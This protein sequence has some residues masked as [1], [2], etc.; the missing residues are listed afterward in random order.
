MASSIGDQA[1]ADA[2]DSLG[3]A[4]G[5][6]GDSAACTESYR[7]AVELFHRAGFPH[8]AGHSW[9]AL[10]GFQEEWG[11]PEAAAASLREALVVFRDIAWHEAEKIH[12]RLTRGRLMR[13]VA[14]PSH[15]P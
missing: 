11:E 13:E 3:L 10:A 5:M 14:P 9:V 4:Y 12:R 1:E 7:R 8:A 6:V 15:V 2:W